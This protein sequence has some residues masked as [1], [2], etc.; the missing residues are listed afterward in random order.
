MI[1]YWASNFFGG[2]H[3]AN[4]NFGEGC[5]ALI[6]EN[7]TEPSL[8]ELEEIL[9]RRGVGSSFGLPFS[10]IKLFGGSPIEILHYQPDPNTHRSEFYYH[11]RENMLFKRYRSN[12]DRLV[13]K[14]V[15]E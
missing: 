3:W 12:D 15:G 1:N 11:S 13:W 2:F 8:S 4:N 7:G 5:L 9:T 6:A 10:F 14:P